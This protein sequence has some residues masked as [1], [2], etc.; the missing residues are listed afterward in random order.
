MYL[1]AKGSRAGCP[2]S[3]RT[4][5]QAHPL[6]HGNGST[7]VIRRF[8]TRRLVNRAVGSKINRPGKVEALRRLP[9][10]ARLGYALMRDARVPAWQRAAA[11]GLVGLIISPLDLPGDVPV[12]GQI[13]DF[14]LAVTVLEAF[15][16]HAPA[17][18]VNEHIIR[19]GLE[20]KYPL[21]TI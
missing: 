10:L 11:V 4:Q 13:W 5:T 19:L 1:P 17:S 12:L 16:S 15:I 14:T 18:V 7:R 9:T 2:L 20:S 21:R 6:G 3:R 8:V